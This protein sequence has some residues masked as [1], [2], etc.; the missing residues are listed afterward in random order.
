M[1]EDQALIRAV[2][3]T[4]WLFVMIFAI[5]GLYVSGEQFALSAL[6][7]G[8]LVNGSFLLLKKDI[9]QLVNK[10]SVAGGGLDS[11]S[12]T[13]KI[14][15]FIKFHARL[16]VFGLL[17]IALVAKCPINL[18]GLAL[19]LATVVLSVV[20]VVLIKGKKFYSKLRLRSV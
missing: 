11:V 8:V 15:F 17:L 18:V 4:G 1:K 13:E 20:V 12:R 7:G 16:V 3:Y 19:G 5:A 6:A 9:E 2:I 14:R 10:V